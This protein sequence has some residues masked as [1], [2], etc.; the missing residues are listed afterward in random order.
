MAK[1]K[2]V[3]P[4]KGFMTVDE[5][6]DFEQDEEAASYAAEQEREAGRKA[7]GKYRF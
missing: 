6:L 4:G 7:L 3:G 2:R 1:A 5:A